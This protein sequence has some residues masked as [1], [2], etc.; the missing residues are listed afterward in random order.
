M[1]GRCSIGSLSNGEDATLGRWIAK[2][3]NGK[4]KISGINK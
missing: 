2:R 4:K 1:L 3:K